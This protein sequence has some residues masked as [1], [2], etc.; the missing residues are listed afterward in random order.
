MELERVEQPICH[1]ISF[2]PSEPAPVLR[3]RQGE[4]WINEPLSSG[5]EFSLL[6]GELK[7]CLGYV[8]MSSA[9]ER[10]H[11]ICP[12]RKALNTGTQCAGCR[13]LDQTKFMHHF[14]RTGEAPAGMRRYLEQ[15]HFLYVASF[16]DGAT[17]VGTTSTQS[18][19]S[20]L[21]TQ[22]A[23]S[24]RY[25]ARANDGAA[26]RVLEDLVTEH[27]G[28][29]QQIRQKAKIKGLCSWDYDAQSL[30]TLNT[31]EAHRAKDFLS[32]QRGLESYGIT[33]LDEPWEHPAYSRRVIDAW[34]KRAIH[35]FSGPLQGESVSVQLHGVLGQGLLVDT[36]PGSALMILD[37][38]QLKTH[39]L[40]M[41]EADFSQQGGQRSLF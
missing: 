28:L 7:W 2:S 38:A 15:P 33:L 37:A 36:G 5:R 6:T 23:V 21:A 13:R 18:K 16:A 20:R 39:A 22:G 35:Q 40:E 41:G 14:H 29:R 10:R 32:H 17:K 11:L 8:T 30:Q 31:S 27:C 4:Q 9:G 1:G 12:K 19:W 25:I 34:N 24:A 3:L 26:I